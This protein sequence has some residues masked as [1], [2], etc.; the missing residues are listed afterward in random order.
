MAT[1][2][3]SV[4]EGA[5]IDRLM[6]VHIVCRDA[7]RGERIL[8]RLARVLGQGTGWSI[9]DR[10][11]PVV[12]LNYFLPYLEWCDFGRSFRETKTAAWFTH[13]DTH[14]RGKVKLWDQAAEGVD[15]RL[16][17]A[18]LYLAE[19]A[20]VGPAGLVTPPLERAK[21][22]PIEGRIRPDKMVVGVSGFVYPGGRKGEGLVK[23]LKGSD[24]GRQIHLRASG[25]GWPVE[26]LHRYKWAELERFYRDLDVYLCTSMI[27]GV[28]Y[29]PLEALACGKPVII[30]RGVGLLDDLPEI[31]G[32]FRYEAGD[33]EG[34]CGALVRAFE[35]QV[36]PAGLREATVRFSRSAWC[37]DHE[38]A[39]GQLLSGRAS[40]QTPE[41]A[42]PDWRGRAGV[43]YVAY[44]RPSREC[45]VRAMKSFRRWMPEIPIC[46]AS[47]A[48]LGI[49]D[50][51]V[52]QSD[53]DIGGRSVKTRIYD[54][55]PAKWKYVLY[56]DADTVV[57]ADISA[58]FG[59]LADGWEFVIC[60]NP[61]KY[62]LLQAM[63]R[64]DNKAE[65]AQTLE[66]LGPGSRQLL[67]L[68]GGVFAFR[69]G[70][71]TRQFFHYWHEE[72]QRWGARDQA[73]LH[74]ALWRQPLRLLLLGNEWNTIP[75]YMD[76]AQ[77]AGILH[78]PTE[79]RRWGGLIE[80][81]LDSEA[82]WKK[83]KN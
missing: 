13:R 65:T 58:L 48:P 14:Q 45:A 64:P 46:L 42:L 21:F 34:M 25:R 77:T 69:R 71:S 28:P 51:F 63:V 8:P 47:D 73:A 12:D 18:R 80:G 37:G 39:F 62:A 81:R 49:E 54:L 59:F 83:V 79:A 76:P 41:E 50:I 23:R 60:K 4:K 75:R 20:K 16:T 56:L 1:A 33:F 3:I 7:E 5:T 32:I 6:R 82:A 66:Q 26:D 17:S 38:A 22:C 2:A 70:A 10:P 43:F 29:P 68:N 72:W 44:G 35:A 27:E 52:K 74:R 19:L 31:P 36:N 55:A 11:V 78:Y 9:G 30:P 15:L 67:Q 40:I 57:T 24:L 61:G 53:A